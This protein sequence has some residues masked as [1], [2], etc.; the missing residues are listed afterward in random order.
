MCATTNVACLAISVLWVSSFGFALRTSNYP[1]C[2]SNDQC[3][4]LTECKPYMNLI[5][6][7]RRPLSPASVQ[8]LRRQECGF[9]GHFPLVCCFNP[10]ANANAKVFFGTEDPVKDFP[11]TSEVPDQPDL[12]PSD[13]SEYRLTKGKLL[14]APESTTT[15]TTTEKST[16]TKLF[17]RRA[18]KLLWNDAE[19]IDDAVDVVEHRKNKMEAFNQAF[20]SMDYFFVRRMMDRTGEINNKP[21]TTNSQVAPVSLRLTSAASYSCSFFLNFVFGK[22]QKY[23]VTVNMVSVWCLCVAVLSLC[24]HGQAGFLSFVPRYLV[25]NFENK[26]CSPT[27]TCIKITDCRFFTDLLDKTPIPRPKWVVT[28]IRKHQC[29]F[30]DNIPKVCCNREYL[31]HSTTT[32]TTPQPITTT[33]NPPKRM[34]QTEPDLLFNSFPGDFYSH[35]NI[36]LLLGHRCGP[37]PQQRLI[38]R[39][40]S[41]KK[42]YL[43]EFPWMAL[44]AYNTPDVGIEFRC[45]GTL[46]S[47]YYVL[48]AAHCILNSTILG[49]RLGEYN[50]TSTQHDCVGTYCAPPVQ[51]FYIQESVIH[52]EYNAKTFDNDIGLLRLSNKA[53]F[54]Y[55]NVQPVCLP[56]SDVN[57]DLTGKFAVVSGWGVTEHGHKSSVLLKAS[58][59]VLPLTMCKRVYS[60]FANIT[61]KQI[62]AG[63]Y[64]GQDSCAGDSGGPLIYTGLVDGEPRYIQYGVVSYG[65]REC[66]T[67]GQPGIYTRVSSYLGWILDNVRG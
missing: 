27:E 24:V 49:V 22:L 65:P 32:T 61:S 31:Q 64:K 26:Q 56:L 53:N 37:I 55:S 11:Q 47:E 6:S 9:D 30:E 46:I 44:I 67:D 14:V 58:V 21:N 66:G 36:D 43:E 20:G 13:L 1:S 8:Y 5:K 18:N 52:P 57:D 51:D 29:G 62:C 16:S 23:F 3:I 50:L 45:G 39:I 28:M 4:R 2:R 33:H 10:S 34:V 42:T 35:P 12:T 60:R 41:G 54:S 25:T 17:R 63:G 59:P 40:T 19:K 15:T 38:N 7:L 48:T